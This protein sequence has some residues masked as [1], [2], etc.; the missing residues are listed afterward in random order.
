VK[1]KQILKDTTKNGNPI[2][3]STK[4]ALD[5]P[6]GGVYIPTKG[7]QVIGNK[8]TD[9]HAL[10]TVYGV[11]EKY[12][13]DLSPAWITVEDWAFKRLTR[14][15]ANEKSETTYQWDSWR[16]K[17]TL[18][19]I[20]VFSKDL[21][22]DVG[23]ISKLKKM[24][25]AKEIIERGSVDD[26]NYKKI[27]NIFSKV[28]E[29]EHRIAFER[30]EVIFNIDDMITAQYPLFTADTYRESLKDKRIKKFLLEHVRKVDRQRKNP[31]IHKIINKMQDV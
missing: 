19:F 27:R 8:N 13:K 29:V 1:I 11:V 15:I 31:D 21:N 4:R 9:E 30:K 10:P 28:P 17:D 22:P 7:R 25:Y 24:I 16:A 5:S 6:R 12:V 18:N 3:S 20:K 23:M 26:T 2:F 14:L